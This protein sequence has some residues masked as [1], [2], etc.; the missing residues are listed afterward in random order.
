MIESQPNI[1]GLPLIVEIQD[2]NLICDCS[3]V[4]LMEVYSMIE[5]REDDK[6]VFAM[7]DDGNVLITDDPKTIGRSTEVVRRAHDYLK[8]WLFTKQCSVSTEAEPKKEERKMTVSFYSIE[9]VQ[10]LE[11]RVAQ[12]ETQLA[13]CTAAAMGATDDVATEGDYGW[14]PAYQDVLELRQKHD[15]LL[16]ARSGGD[17]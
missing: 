9:Y 12:L 4:F 13:G 15:A 7:Y 5:V 16:L 6:T 3:P 2:K 8:H 10:E 11:E 17:W 14:S 1:D